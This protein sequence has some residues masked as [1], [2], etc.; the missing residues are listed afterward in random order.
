MR[1]MITAVEINA[2]GFIF[3]VIVVEM[4]EEEGIKEDMKQFI[5]STDAVLSIFSISLGIISSL[6]RYMSS[7]V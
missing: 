2:K 5:Y 3:V 1:R 4:E 7:G 6:V